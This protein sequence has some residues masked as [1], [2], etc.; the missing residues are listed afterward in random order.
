M[1]HRNTMSFLGK[2]LYV[3]I[4]SITAGEFFQRSASGVTRAQCSK[5]FYRDQEAADVDFR[6][7]RE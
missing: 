4:R 2:Y 3:F 7:D 5:D 1:D 6:G